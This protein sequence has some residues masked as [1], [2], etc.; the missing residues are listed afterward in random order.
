VEDLI[1][2]LGLRAL[3]VQEPTA[4][5]LPAHIDGTSDTRSGLRACVEERLPSLIARAGKTADSAVALIRA[6]EAPVRS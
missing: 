2:E 6:A 1:A 4:G 5:R 3:P